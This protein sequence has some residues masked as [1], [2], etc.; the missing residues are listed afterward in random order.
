MKKY[1]D[2]YGSAHK[3]RLADN[4][5]KYYGILMPREEAGSELFGD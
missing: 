4:L 2:F 3:L 5:R 1:H